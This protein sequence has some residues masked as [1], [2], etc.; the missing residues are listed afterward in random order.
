MRAIV[1]E[2]CG[3]SEFKY[4]NGIYTCAYCGTRYIFVGKE[5][6]AVADISE[7]VTVV[8][9]HFHR[10]YRTYDYLYNLDEPVRVGDILIVNGFNGE[11]QVTVDRVATKPI[12]E[13]P[14]PIYAYKYVLRKANIIHSQ[15]VCKEKRYVM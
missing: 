14:M 4:E 8:S 12:T 11:T 13:L 1:C 3:A 7:I 2:M 5:R 9:V 10:S 15:F 6:L